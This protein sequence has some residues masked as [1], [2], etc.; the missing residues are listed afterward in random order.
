VTLPYIDVKI[1]TEPVEL[2]ADAFNYL[3]AKVPGWLPSPGNLEAWLIE[4]LAQIAGELRVLVG[5]VPEEIF[6]YYGSSIMGLPPYQAV[7]ATAV[8]RWTAKDDAG[9]DVF[10]GTVVGLHPPASSDVWAFEVV[11]DFHI[12]VTEDGGGTDPPP[13]V[14]PGASATLTTQGPAANDD[15]TYTAPEGA[16][17]NQTTVTYVKPN[18]QNA[19]LRCNVTGQDIVV[20][21]KTG[22]IPYASQSTASQ[23][24]ALVN[25]DAAASALVT[26]TLAPGSTGIDLCN[27]MAKAA[28]TGG[29]DAST[30]KTGAPASTDATIQALVPGAGA[31]G[32][33]GELEMIDVLDFIQTV[34]LVG[35]TQGGQD[36]ETADEYL[37]RLSD[38][39]TLL[40][41]RP[42]LPWDFAVMAK[43]M[44]PGVDRCCAID[45]YNADT[46]ETNVPRCCTVVPIDEN[47][48]PVSDVIAAEI[49]ALLQSQREINFLAFVAKPTYTAVD[50]TFA[51]VVYQLYDPQDVALRVIAQLTSYLSPAAWGL[52]PYGDTGSQSWINETSVRYLEVAEQINRVDGVHYVRTLTIGLAGAAQGTV[53]LVLP[54]VAPLTTPG[55]IDG[56]GQA[57]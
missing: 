48:D 28:L 49:D 47:G 33:T 20:T 41:P 1:E 3:E 46:G 4:S 9:Y 31:S 5:L 40:S 7:P 44:V 27:A 23:I 19:T 42:I 39:L 11:E 38:L 10:A 22:P 16:A 50:V 8:S 51:V 12:G 17:G 35:P 34:E 30:G 54:G 26:V 55:A 53:D 57:S 43:T 24:M 37:D 21:L 15:L 52:P 6:M 45:L 14:I 36:A 2:A 18:S 25:A 56:T 29:V 13:E 32:L